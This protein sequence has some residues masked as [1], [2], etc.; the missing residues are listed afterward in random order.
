M[1]KVHNQL[2]IGN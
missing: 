2:T 1:F